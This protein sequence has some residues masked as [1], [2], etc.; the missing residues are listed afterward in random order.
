MAQRDLRQRLISTLLKPRFA[1]IGNCPHLL[2]VG[3]STSF[4]TLTVK[5]ARIA[6]TSWWVIVRAIGKLNP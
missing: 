4:R 6:E 2:S 3:A 1:F 5:N